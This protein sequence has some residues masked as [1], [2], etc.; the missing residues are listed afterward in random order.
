MR[1]KSVV[2]ALALMTAVGLGGAAYADTM[3]NGI[4]V[5]D[6]DLPRVQAYCEQLQS[7]MTPDDTPSDSPESPLSTDAVGTEATPSETEGDTTDDGTTDDG[8][9][10]DGAT[11]SAG[12]DADGDEGDESSLELGDITLQGCI[13]AGLIPAAAQ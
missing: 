7:G 4:N 8:T 6:A 12:E 13:D 9:T 2:S 5:S 1:F 11:D 3:V 10:D